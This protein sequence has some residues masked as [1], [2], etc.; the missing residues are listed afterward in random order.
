VLAALEPVLAEIVVTEN[1]SARGLPVDD[2]AAE[3]VDVFGSD[4]VDVQPR[5]D[6]AL[7]V[8][9]RLAEEEGPLGSSGVIVTGSLVTVGEARRLLRAGTR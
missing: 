1:G 2:L 7:D 4:R 6:D 9:V 8:A 3:A 5:L